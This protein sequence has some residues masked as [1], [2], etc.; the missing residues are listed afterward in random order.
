MTRN[1]NS[2]RTDFKAP[3]TAQ[4]HRADKLYQRQKNKRNR[5]DY[6]R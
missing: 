5:S 4:K 6:E 1:W 2:P 3:R